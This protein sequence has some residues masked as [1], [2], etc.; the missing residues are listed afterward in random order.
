MKVARASEVLEHVRIHIQH[1]HVTHTTHTHVRIHIQHRQSHTQSTR[2]IN[3]VVHTQDPHTPPAQ[4][5][6]GKSR[7][8][9]ARRS[10]S[11]PHCGCLVLWCHPRAARLETPSDGRFGASRI[12]SVCGYLYLLCVL[13]WILLLLLLS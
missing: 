6:T 2:R 5:K 10:A 4:E 3:T 8:D 11:R 12:H 7:L 9:K 1:R 13:S